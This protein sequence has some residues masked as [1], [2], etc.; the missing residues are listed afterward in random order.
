MKLKKSLLPILVAV[1]AAAAGSAPLSA[2]PVFYIGTNTLGDTSLN[3][4]EIIN[5]ENLYRPFDGADDAT[6]TGCQAYDP[7]NDPA[8]YR[9]VTTGTDLQVGDLFLGV[10]S[11]RQISTSEQGA[12]WNADSV[13]PGIDE[14]T[15]YFAQEIK[16]VADVDAGATRRIMLGGLSVAD[17]FGILNINGTD[18]LYG[19]ADDISAGF[20]ASDTKVALDGA[21]NTTFNSIATATDGTLWAYL[22]LGTDNSGTAAAPSFESDGY[23]WSEFDLTLAT[24]T[25]TANLAYDII[26][27]GNAFNL[28][29]VNPINDPA[30]LLVGGA[31]LGDPGTTI[32]NNYFGTCVPSATYAC[33][34]LV[35]NTQL[36][37]NQSGFSPW[38]FASEDPIQ[39]NT[40]PEPTTLGLL[41][42]GLLGMG[43][44]LRRR[45]K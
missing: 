42:L 14:F 12:V 28:A 34:D 25:G 10:L 8:G 30:E 36:S 23:A 37:V 18:G 22:G 26:S 3:D 21:L 41:G 16:S 9:R 31:I 20:W 33:N 24:F 11:S 38:A 19:T 45:A 1:A 29:G 39:V 15:G 4:I 7:N 32:A 13:A 27:T 2:A 17:P 6:C 40:I 35:G 43:T 44:S 5:R